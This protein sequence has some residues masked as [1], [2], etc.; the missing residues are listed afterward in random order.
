MSGIIFGHHLFLLFFVGWLIVRVATLKRPVILI[1]TMIVGGV[2]TCCCLYVKSAED[3]AVLHAERK[4]NMVLRVYPDQIKVNGNTAQIIGQDIATKQGVQIFERIKTKNEQLKWQQINETCYYQVNGVQQ[5]LMPATNQNQFDASSYLLS[6]KIESQLIVDRIGTFTVKNEHGY[7]FVVN[8]CHELRK[9]LMNYFDTMPKTLRLYCNSLIIGNSVTEFSMSM[10]SIKQLGLIHL[11]CISGMHVVLLVSIIERLLIH[12]KIKIETIRWVL[13]LILPFYLII[14]GN[15]ASLIRATMM[16]EIGLLA[17]HQTRWQVSKL[18]IWSFSLLI[19]IGYEPRVLMSLG[20]QLS[21]LLSLMLKFLPEKSNPFINAILMNLVGLPVILYFIFEWHCLSLIASYLMIPVFSVAIF[22]AVLVTAIGYLFLPG[23]GQVCNACL[24]LFQTIIAAI[25]Q[26]PGMIHFGKTNLLITIGLFL[27]TIFLI[28]NYKSK[29]R[30]I[31]LLTMYLM[32]FISVHYP[33]NGEVTFVDIGQG[34]SIILISP[35]HRQVTMIDTGGQ[36]AFPMPHWAQRITTGD[37]ATRVTVN[38]LKS[39]GISKINNLCLS[40]QDTDHIGFSSSILQNMQ[41]EQ[42][43][44]PAG[45][46]KQSNFKRNV[47]PIAKRKKIKLIPVVAGQEVPNL[48]LQVLHPFKAGHGA[49]ED[50]VVLA[51]KFGPKKFVFTGDLDQAGEL[52]VT[53]QYPQLRADVL[54][55]GHHG[56]KTATHPDFLKQLNP[57]IAII[58]A[59][60]RNRY[61]HPNQETLKTLTQQNV[62][63][64]STQ[65]MGMISYYYRNDGY[66]KWRTKLKGDELEWMLKPSLLK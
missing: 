64:L 42:I 15:S 46:E 4:A 33:L 21:Y 34:D 48:P 39:K 57:K 49:N 66:E 7:Q 5:P 45:M 1:T 41:I 32:T 25:A 20:G 30:W 12:L 58:S 24:N 62:Q 54:K 27:L 11:F 35:F 10:N 14:G 37:K 18:D 13:I 17:A 3:R 60:R 28:M 63:S 61:G 53:K 26:L 22:P 51:G 47:L 29:L 40:H 52:A 38:Y 36:L 9:K 16:S 23:I 50:S 8:Y 65:K 19:G 59:G 43:S 2:A 55:L 44:F 56:S 31:A 6:K